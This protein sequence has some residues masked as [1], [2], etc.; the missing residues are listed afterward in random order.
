MLKRSHYI[1]LGLVA[2]LALVVFNLPGRTAARLK[3]AFGSLF[4]PLFG[5]VGA[6]Q[7][8]AAKVG[9]SLVSRREL[10]TQN[11][12]LRRENQK[13]QVQNLQ[14][15]ELARENDRLRQLVGWQKTQPQWK[16]KLARVVMRDPA[17]WW[18]TV[19]IDIGSRDGV[20]TN[21]PVLTPEGLVG[22]THSVS[23]DHAQVVLVGDPK[24]NVA[25]RVQNETHDAGIVGAG[26]PLDTSLVVMSFLPA[27][28]HLK[29]GQEVMTSG[30]GG[31]FPRGI[32]IGQIVDS[33]PAEFG[34]YTEA[35]IKLNANLAG[36]EELWVVMP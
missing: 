36:L 30:D 6:S 4:L 34:L 2:L 7:Q 26:G 3:L 25:A 16:L 33:R 14:L 9:D 11:D 8:A 12:A 15:D 18:R 20:R 31:V 35:R 21:L 28:A 5:L 17:N 1:T 10:E 27:R 23:F 32:S 24:C 29:A 13:L 22:R 19:Q